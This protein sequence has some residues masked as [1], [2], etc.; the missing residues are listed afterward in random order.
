MSPAL[1]GLVPPPHNGDCSTDARSQ[2][3]ASLETPCSLE[4][5]AGEAIK[6]VEDAPTGPT[7]VTAQPRFRQRRR[8]VLP[9]AELIGE[10][11]PLTLAVA[12]LVAFPDQSMTARS[13]QGEIDRGRLIGEKIGGRWYTTTGHIR[14]MRELCRA[15]PKGLG[16]TSENERGD[17]PFLS[18]STAGR[19]KSALDALRLT[20][21]GLKKHSPT[22]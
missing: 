7:V 20:A 19:A 6:L 18:S 1:S 12:A 2:T 14:R 22:T 13:L 16:S 3:S 4:D 10:D 9:P 15:N 17:R 5:Q 21:S 8:A 11:T